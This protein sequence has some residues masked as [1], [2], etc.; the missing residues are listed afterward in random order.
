[1]PSYRLTRTEIHKMLNV[2]ATPAPK[3]FPKKAFDC[4]YVPG[5][6]VGAG[7]YLLAPGQVNQKKLQELEFF[8]QQYRPLS[9]FE[10]KTPFFC[11]FEKQLS[12][13]SQKA[14][15]ARG[16]KPASKHSFNIF[17]KVRPVNI[18]KGY[19]LSVG[20]VQ[21]RRELQVHIGLAK[22]IFQF[23]AL[24]KP[25]RRFCQINGKRMYIVNIYRDTGKPIATSIV[26]HKDGYA[27][28]FSGSILPAHQ[29]KGLWNTMVTSRQAVTVGHGVHTWYLT[30]STKA[31]FNKGDLRK[32]YT[33]WKKL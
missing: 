2:V 27:G 30:T 16:F 33:V 25:V 19:R 17:R 12:T 18:P 20:T 7:A 29:G 11:A 15:K 10:S 24:E 3:G 28:L 26:V 22:E 14:L 1:M 9:V 23:D 4:F 31:I 32:R 6:F 8:F 21:D 5:M 13:N